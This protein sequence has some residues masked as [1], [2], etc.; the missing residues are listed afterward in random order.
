V[1]VLLWAF[2]LESVAVT[3]KVKVPLRLGVPEMT[4]PFDIVSP[5]G[6][7]PDEILHL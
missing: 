5:D 2:E 7:L 1:T 6:R 4:P 3:L